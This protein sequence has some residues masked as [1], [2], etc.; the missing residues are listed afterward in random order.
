MYIHMR[1]KAEALGAGD[2]KETEL[3]DDIVLQEVRETIEAEDKLKESLRK[4]VNVSSEIGDI[5]ALSCCAFQPT[6]KPSLIATGSWSGRCKIWEM[7]TLKEQSILE[8]HTDMLTDLAFHPQSGRGQSPQSLNLVT[9]SAD[10]TIKLW[11]TESSQPLSSLEGHPRKV[12]KVAFHPT[13]DYLASSSFDHTWRLW[14]VES[15]ENLIIQEGHAHPITSI[16]FH[17]DG[18]LLV[19]AGTDQ[20]ARIWDLRSGRSIMTLKGHIK[21]IWHRLNLLN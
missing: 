7:S 11:S 15:G 21:P 6:D 3:E 5:R 17:Q 8:G 13:G 1:D 10:S 19:S 18:S 14:N 2:I 12:S 4:Y 16:A 9:C 20:I